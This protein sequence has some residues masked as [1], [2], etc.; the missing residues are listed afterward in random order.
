MDY[1]FSLSVE[2]RKK[3]C[4]KAKEKWLGPQFYG[5]TS[6][7]YWDG[8][9]TY[10]SSSDYYTV[11]MT[12]SLNPF[13]EAWSLIC[14]HFF[15]AHCELVCSLIWGFL[16]VRKVVIKV[17]RESERGHRYSERN[18]GRE[19]KVPQV[20]Y[21]MKTCRHMIRYFIGQNFWRLL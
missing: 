6:D 2:P 13:T 21:M 18:W 11:H 12:S 14:N 4:P 9:M 5:M 20:W 1:I 17:F 16:W 7:L 15:G 8:L 10:R 19:R 3:K